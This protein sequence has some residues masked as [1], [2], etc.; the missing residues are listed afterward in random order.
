[1]AK[2]ISI[3]I[4][5][6]EGMLKEIT[7]QAMDYETSI[8]AVIRTRLRNGA[9][10]KSLAPGRSIPTLP[11]VISSE[12]AEE[13]IKPASPKMP[14]EEEKAASLLKMKALYEKEKTRR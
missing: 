1:M 5:L 12:Q 13:Q 10:H 4:T 2:K 3:T 8:S 14:T 7:Q 9:Y 11:D 6:E